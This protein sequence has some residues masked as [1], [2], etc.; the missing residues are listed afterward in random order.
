[1]NKHWDFV[2]TVFYSTATMACVFA[3][4]ALLT[5]VCGFTVAIDWRLLG[6]PIAGWIITVL[7]EE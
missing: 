6:L 4:V 2:E 5:W 1:M 3:A 7:D